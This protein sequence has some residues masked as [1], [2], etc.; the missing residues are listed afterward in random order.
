MSWRL[1]SSGGAPF[2]K[3]ESPD[4]MAKKKINKNKR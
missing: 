3:A 2:Y 1:G 4:F